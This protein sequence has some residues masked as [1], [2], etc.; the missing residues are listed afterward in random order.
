MSDKFFVGLN[1][2]GVE[3]NGIQR[4]I[5][6][7]TFLL[8]DENSVTAGDD[9]GAELLASC[10]HA[11]QEMAD[12]ILDQVRGYQY[13]MLGADDA[14]LDPAAELGDGVTAGGLYSVISRL[15]DDGS[16]YV[17]ITAP[18]TSELEDE[19]PAGGPMTQEF[20]RKISRTNSRITKTAEQIRLEVAKE[21]GGLSSAIDIRLDGITQKVEDNTAGLS[22][23]LRVAA[24]GVTITNA[25]GSTL[26]I[27]GGQIDAR[28]IRTDQLDA[29]G[30]NASDLRLT[31]A[32]T[33]SDLANDA[34]GQ[35]TSAQNTASSAL[36]AASR[37]ANT[38]SGWTYPGSTYINGSMLMTGTVKATSIQ[39]GAVAL[40][41]SSGSISGLMTITSAQTGAYAVDLSSYSAL[42]LSANSGLLYLSGGPDIAV[43]CNHF[44]PL[45]NAADLGS[46]SQGMWNAVYAYTGEIIT[47]DRG[48]KRDIEPIPDKYL[49]MLDKIRPVRFKVNS[50]TSG[51][52]HT[53]FVAQEVEAAMEASGISS[54]E[55][56]GWCRD[57]DGEGNELQM[58]RYAEFIPL[59]A[60]KLRRLEERVF[61][62][63]RVAL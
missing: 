30:I 57:Q 61:E 22:Q 23:T 34:K 16:G 50:G 27:D 56:A 31:G 51:R 26:T 52:Y 24:D 8:D 37:A 42:R 14:A 32:I 49:D 36:D 19:Y 4:P 46:T 10:P 13:Q 47:S 3:D 45:G 58:L 9:T 11:T 60:A 1:L 33:W 21:V 6:R 29:S 12:A 62:L 53:G 63:E 54:Q 15:Q 5:S 59:Y 2:T 40:L 7:V 18:G 43:G 25:Q 39:G 28:G 17:G 44:Y 35:V 55:F 41:D 20:T 48:S 38:V